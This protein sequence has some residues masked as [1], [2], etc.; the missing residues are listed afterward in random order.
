MHEEETDQGALCEQDTQ[1]STKG[2]SRTA[3]II[4]SKGNIL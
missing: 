3:K 1:T 2:T 4:E